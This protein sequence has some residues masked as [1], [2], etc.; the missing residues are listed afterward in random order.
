[1]ERKGK[2]RKKNGEN[3]IDIRNIDARIKYFFFWGKK[4]VFYRNNE[5]EGTNI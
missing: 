4:E 1:M 3:S 2:E 5:T